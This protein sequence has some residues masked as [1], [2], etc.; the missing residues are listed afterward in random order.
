[1]I[2]VVHIPQVTP[3]DHILPNFPKDG[4]GK[5]QLFLLYLFIILLYVK[6]L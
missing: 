5:T 4:Y 1:M 6:V 3:T 2:R